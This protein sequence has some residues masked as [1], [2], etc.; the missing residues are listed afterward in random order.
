MKLRCVQLDE[1]QAEADRAL[2]EQTEQRTRDEARARVSFRRQFL[3]EAMREQ[4]E[5]WSEARRLRA[6]AS[7]IR[8]SVETS[9][10]RNEA[11]LE[12]ASEIER[13]AD[14]IDSL[15][16]GARAPQ[17]PEPSY[18]ELRKHLPKQRW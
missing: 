17:I 9:R 14:R 10:S 7:A 11:A 5:Q 12:W 18:T 4:A 2:D 13:E 16:L 8:K 1:A 6:Y 3:A 15:C